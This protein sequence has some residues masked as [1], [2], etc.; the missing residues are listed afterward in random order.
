MK[1]LKVLLSV[2]SLLAIN[3]SFSYGQSNNVRGMYVKDIDNWLGDAAAEN[4][5]LAYAQGNAYTYITFY[6]LGSLN[7][8]SSTTKNTLASLINRA[9][10]QYGLLQI[11]AAG[12]NA[13]FFSNNIIPYNNGRGAATE[14]FDVLNF[15][16]EFWVSSSISSMYC[17]KYLSPNGYSCDTAGA[18]KFAKRELGTIKSLASAY[19]LISEVYLGWPNKGQMQFIASTVDRI[20]LHA[21]RTNDA[22][23]YQYSKGRLIDA[24]SGG[25]PV[26]VIP[27]FSAEP[28]FMG[29]W[30]NSNPITKP[31]QSY[32]N[33]YA[34]ETGTWKQNINLQGYQW[35]T[36]SELPKT[37]SAIAAITASGP[38]T[39]CTGGNVTLTA[40][41]GAQYLWYPGGQTTRSIVVTQTGSYSVRVTNT[42]GTNVTSSVVGVTSGSTGSSPTITA[43]GSLAL[44]TTNPTV[45]LSTS[46]ATSYLWSTGATTQ[47]ITVSSAGSYTVTVNGTSGCSAVSAPVNVSSSGCVLPAVPVVTSS[48]SLN[49]CSGGTVTLTSSTASGYLWSTGAVTKSITVS[50]AGTYWVRAYS[51]GSCSTQS[52]NQIITGV[53]TAIPTISASGS[54]A[55]TTSNPSVT[56]TSSVASSYVWSTGETT[57]SINVGTAGSFYVTIPGTTGCSATSAAVSVTKSGCTPPAVP[58]I[59]LSGSPVLQTGQSVTLTSP[60]AGGYLWSTWVGTRSIVVSTPGTYWV[61]NYSGPSCYSTSVAVTITRATSV[62]RMKNQEEISSEFSVYPNPATTQITFSFNVTEEREV[63]FVFFDITGR[64]VIRRTIQAEAGENKIEIPTSD[65]AR[66]IYFG[67]LIMEDKKE[68]IKL[69][70]Q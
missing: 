40:N 70:L 20:L 8:N 29:S 23:V 62:S 15:E 30:L 6:D 26:K 36:Y 1:K 32:S 27:I 51:A 57:R 50:T 10:T 12:E 31:Y 47:S 35:F 2:L 61:R 16:F 60:T 64:E 68:T 3:M 7:F 46:T 17:S 34:A 13:A 9:K 21:Y 14:K 52:V 45:T 5:I 55:L 67:N 42:S 53:A 49:L 63:L 43:S 44:T 28:A 11:G 65:Y 22:D 69:I 33:G 18:Y 54:L 66:G 37:T 25:V 4:A 38:T 58:V 19:G 59:T 56:L 48:G 39:F 41:S 24:A